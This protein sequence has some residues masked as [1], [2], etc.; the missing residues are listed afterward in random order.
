M[1]VG[2]KAAGFE[3]NYSHHSLRGHAF[4]SMRSGPRLYIDAS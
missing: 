2:F 3:P 1:A 4:G